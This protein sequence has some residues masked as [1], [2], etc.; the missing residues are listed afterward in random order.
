MNM[1]LIFLSLLSLLSFVEEANSLPRYLAHECPNTTSNNDS[2]F[3]TNLG[4]FLADLARQAY[5]NDKYSIGFYNAT[6]GNDP[7]KL[8]ALFLCSGDVNMETCQRCVNVATTNL[9][10]DLCPSREQSIIWYDECLFRYSNQSFFSIM[11]QY[12]NAIL[13]NVNNITDDADIFAEKVNSLLTETTAEVVN[14]SKMF[15]TRKVNF[16]ALSTLYGLLQCTPDLSKLDCNTCL[17]DAISTMRSYSRQVGARVMLPSCNVRFELYPFYN[18]SVPPAPP[19]L[20]SPLPP[21]PPLPSKSNVRNTIPPPPPPPP[22]LPS[23]EEK[24]TN[25]HEVQVLHLG[26]NSAGG[27][28]PYNIIQGQESQEFPHFPLSIILEATHNFCDE[29]KLGEG[30]FGPVYKGI[31]VDGKEIAVKRLS[32]T[33]GQGLRELKNEVTLISKLQHKNLVRLLGCCLERNESMLIY[34]YMPNKSLDFLLFDST[35]SSDLDWK[36]RISIINGIARGLLYLH[37]DSR[38]KVIHRDL[39]TSNV[40]LDNEMNPRISDFGMARI[41][42]GNQNEA[43]TKRVVGT[44]GYMAPE[45]AMEGLFSV[46]SDVFSFGV[47]MLEIL[48]GKKNS[49]FYLLKH[50]QSLLNYAWKLWCEGRVLELMDPVM[51][52][53]CVPGELLEG[54]YILKYIHVG[55]LCVQEDPADRP[56]MSSLVVMLATDTIVLSKPTEPAFSV[57]RVVNLAQSSSEG[58]ISSSMNEHSLMNMIL[59]FLSLLRLLSFVVEASPRYVGHDCWNTTFN[60]GSAHK[61]KLNIFL[62]DFLRDAY[63]HNKYSIGFY[64]ATAGNDPDKL[65]ALFLCRGDVSL[66]ICERCV[67]VATK[68]LTDLCPIGEQSIIWYDECFFRYS[69]ESF[70]SIMSKDP[71][72]GYRNTQNIAGSAE[73][74]GEKLKSLLTKATV[75]ALNTSK[76]F[77][78]RK[79]NLDALRTLYVLVQCTPDLSKL[80]CNTCLEGA[81]S[82]LGRYSTYVGARVMS[83]SCNARYELY[84]FYNEIM[85][86]APPPLRSPPSPPLPSEGQTKIWIEIGV[87][88]SLTIVVVLGSFLLWR[89]HKRDKEE[90]ATSNHVVQLLRLEEGSVGGDDSYDIIQ[91]QETQEFPHFSLG[92]ILEATQ[93]FSDENKLGEGGFGPVYKGILV[94]G[95]EIAVKRLSRTSGQGLKELKNEVTLISKLQHKNLVRLLGCCLEGNE[96]M[97]IYEY[98]PNKSLDFLLFDSTKS[99]E[100]DWKRRIRIINGIARGLLYLHEDSRLKVIHRDLKTSN[101]LLDNEMNPRIS[102]FGMARIFGGNQ[103][104]A[105]TKRVVGTYGYMAPE[106]AMEGLFSVKS[107]VF[108]F[109]VLLLEILSGKKNRFYLSEHGQ[110]LLNYA[111]KLW[112]KGRALEL[113]DPVLVQSCVSVELLKYIHVGL[114]CVQEDPIDR[115]TMSSLV[116]MLA[117]DTIVLPKPTEPAFSV[118]RVVNLA[119]SSFEAKVSSSKNEVTLSSVSPR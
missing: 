32:R 47:I 79:V 62:T 70:F 83:P 97:L 108:S 23:K 114:L 40:L 116:V 10:T 4:L 7:D 21:P 52:Q 75:E 25:D 61:T 13:Y 38:L 65:Y 8:Y 17:E 26:E 39:K 94:D 5:L 88:G 115:P 112:C 53:S 31:L 35:R 119:Q 12:P 44:Y 22:P 78:T 109:G 86:P 72:H 16:T 50:G 101:I 92:I 30:G 82:T 60:T 80:D 59:I 34:E 90:K 58:K 64:N 56:I 48:S 37:E 29:N 66:D 3:Q 11:S 33:S 18:E 85:P 77:A 69:N 111:W 74:F 71:S 6:K 98:M 54:C 105:N 1:I 45:Y 68:N 41:F 91:G 106:Y 95:K 100:L 28:Y 9:T 118:G 81:V 15:A 55:L 46:K 51:V 36:R 104:E 96:S 14:S 42:G 20:L 57:G 76:M 19:P 110:S 49:G 107:D 24:L 67:T 113:M 87:T 99:P 73:I 84:K 117:M 2:A 102:D 103:D 89:R 93:N 63:L 43:N 27:D